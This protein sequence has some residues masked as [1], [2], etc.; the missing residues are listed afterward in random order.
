[1]A[2]GGKPEWDVRKFRRRFERLRLWGRQAGVD[3]DESILFTHLMSA[4]LLTAPRRHMVLSFFENSH[5]E[6]NAT[7]LQS[8]TVRLFGQYT[9]EPTSTFLGEQRISDSGQ[10]SMDTKE[11]LAAQSFKKKHKPGMETAAV[12]RTARNVDMPNGRAFLS[13]NWEMGH[14]IQKKEESTNLPWKALGETPLGA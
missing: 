12:R 1:M 8:I 10:S 14:V 6:K 2:F 11:V 9:P 7:N 4:L 3:L 5:A 13:L